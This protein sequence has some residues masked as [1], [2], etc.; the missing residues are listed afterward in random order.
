MITACAKWGTNARHPLGIT[1]MS[2][3]NDLE[4]I[5]AQRDAQAFRKLF[6]KYG[7]LVK[8]FMM[9]QGVDPATAEE[10]SQETLIS[11]WKKA[12]L[13]AREKGSVTTWIFA[14]ARNLRIDRIR[15]EET[16]SELPDVYEQEAS[17]DAP[18]DEVIAKE[19]L[20]LKLKQ[21]LA[22]LPPEQREVIHLSFIE[23]LTHGD[24]AQRLE[25]PAGTVKSR[26]RLAYLKLRAQ[27]EDL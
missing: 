25:L 10:L 4:R 26:L 18:A 8:A 5:A 21:A 23:G 2:D 24:I 27:V 11:V 15:M 7:P 19:Q 6:E 12:N 13:Y 9:K 20:H 16:W 3:F 17:A 22:L 1:S 14:I